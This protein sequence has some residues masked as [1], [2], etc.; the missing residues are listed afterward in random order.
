M[1]VWKSLTRSFTGKA[2]LR[3]TFDNDVNMPRPRRICQIGGYLHTQVL[4]RLRVFD[5]ATG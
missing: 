4:E 3:N 2:V 1:S 5:W